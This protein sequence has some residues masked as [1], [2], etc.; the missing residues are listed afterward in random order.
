MEP[1]VAGVTVDGGAS[2]GPGRPVKRGRTVDRVRRE[3]RGRLARPRDRRRPEH[4][5]T[6]EDTG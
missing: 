2:Q 4:E 6:R 3:E 1:Y 5:G